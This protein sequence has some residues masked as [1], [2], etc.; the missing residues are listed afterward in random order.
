MFGFDGQTPTADPNLPLP[1]I[2]AF[3]ASPSSTAVAGDVVTL[4]WTTDGA[5]SL[6]IDQGVGSVTGLTGKTVAPTVGTTYTLSATN[7][8]GTVTKTVSV[9]VAGDAPDA[10][11]TGLRLYE[12][13][14]NFDPTG[15]NGYKAGLQRDLVTAL[16][17]ALESG[18]LAPP[19]DSAATMYSKL[20]PTLVDMYKIRT[21]KIMFNVMRAILSHKP[22]PR[23]PERIFP[24]IKVIMDGVTN[25]WVE[26]P[27]AIV[28]GSVDGNNR[29]TDPYSVDG[30]SGYGT[31][32]GA[33]RWNGK[34]DSTDNGGNRTLKGAYHRAQGWAST[35]DRRSPMFR[36]N[37]GKEYTQYKKILFLH[38]ANQR[39]SVVSY[40]THLHDLDNLLAHC[41]IFWAG[42]I[43]DVNRALDPQYGVYADLCYDDYAFN[44]WCPLM[45]LTLAQRHTTYGY[46]KF[47]K[48]LYHNVAAHTGIYDCF[49]EWRK[50]RN[51]TP[52][53]NDVKALKYMMQY[54]IDQ[55]V[56]YNMPAGFFT[57]S[58]N[59]KF[60]NYS[61]ANEPYRLAL[62]M[63]ADGQADTTYDQEFG[64]EIYNLYRRGCQDDTGRV[65]TKAAFA[66]L[67][68]TYSFVV[69]PK[70]TRN[71]YFN[72]NVAG[73]VAACSSGTSTYRKTHFND[74]AKSV[75]GVWEGSA[76]STKWGGK[77]RYYTN[78]SS[79]PIEWY[80]ELP[81]EATGMVYQGLLGGWYHWAD[82][83]PNLQATRIHMRRAK[84]NYGSAYR[85]IP[86]NLLGNPD[87]PLR[88]AWHWLSS[89]VINSLENPNRTLTGLDLSWS[90]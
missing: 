39:S 49:I 88:K 7:S 14:P 6:S 67:S 79:K 12:A 81:V 46:F 77:N 45:E 68:K 73:G 71:D 55:F 69:E 29:V 20:R 48:A 30:P 54:Q 85:L 22:D 66:A 34:T 42:Y 33:I 62:S 70:Q 16:F 63:A 1:T 3:T 27:N 87:N 9:T 4:A 31:G 61:H 41:C 65:L 59:Y 50:L 80:P 21:P 72:G 35:T 82:D 52:D 23:C 86:D 5:T 75:D 47:K 19:L 56:Y 78:H 57:G 44:H 11:V 32:D 36:N 26:W 8:S 40:G 84:N 43:M 18:T 83:T 38:E 60:A 51:L 37:T 25:D 89:Y 90:A 28:P 58:E 64:G 76:I 15:A 17:G 24:F 53:P 2:S 74:G 13:D 10:P